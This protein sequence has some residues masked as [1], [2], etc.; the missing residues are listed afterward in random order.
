MNTNKTILIRN[1][2]LIDPL[3]QRDG[4]QDLLISDGKVAAIGPSL[5]DAA[6]LEVDATGCIVVPGLLD[7]HAHHF[8]GTEDRFLSNGPFSVAPDGF[9]F[10]SGVTTAV[11]FG[12][13]GWKNIELFRRNIVE[14]S[15][16]RILALINI[17]G[18]GMSGEPWEQ[19]IT[20]MDP[21]KTAKAAKENNDIVVGVKLAHYLKPE[22]TPTE[23]TVE[24]GRIANIPVAIDFGGDDRYAPLSIETLFM[25]KLRPGDIYTHVYADLKRREQIVDAFTG[26]LKPFVWEARKKGVL[27][28]L[29]HGGYS[30]AFSQAIPALAEGFLPDAIS[31]D[32]HTF[33]MNEA[34]KDMMNV[35]S[36]MMALGM[37]M[38]EVVKA[39]TSDAAAM[40]RR[41]ELGHLGIGA[42]ADVA[43]LSIREGRFGFTDVLGQKIIGSQKLECELTIRSGEVVYD[44]NGMTIQ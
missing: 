3:H 10:R 40:I 28:D 5:K 23:R 2:R 11:D 21:G 38:Y 44:L 32:L 41:P 37:S 8:Y 20:D 31:T 42:E 39:S 17:L 9:T 43:V 26:K 4:I 15:K 14:R 33:S 22:W 30:F 36:K 25:D 27:F 19:D 6:D 29:G 7:V 34:M 35:I 18:E 24:A 1:G 13:P 12:G 16:T